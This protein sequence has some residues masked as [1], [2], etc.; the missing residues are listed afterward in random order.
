MLT[1][2]DCSIWKTDFFKSNTFDLV[3]YILHDLYLK[4]KFYMLFDFKNCTRNWIA[5]LPVGED[6]YNMA[7]SGV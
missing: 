1:I 6:G 3:L 2:S 7:S 4:K 5:R